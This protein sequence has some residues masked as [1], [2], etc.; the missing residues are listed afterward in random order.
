MM[1]MLMIGALGYGSSSD[2]VRLRD[3]LSRIMRGS[4]RAR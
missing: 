2:E 4:A 1:R 3:L